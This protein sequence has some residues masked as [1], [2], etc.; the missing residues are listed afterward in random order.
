MRKISSKSTWWNKKAFPAMWFGFLGVFMCVLIPGVTQG[1]APAFLLLWPL[2]LA[3]FGYVLMR[4]LVFSLMDEVWIDGDDIVV[5]NR[6]EE[7]RFPI[8]NIVNVD[9]S[10]MTNPERIVLTLRTPSE[11]GQEIVF[12]PLSRWWPFSRHPLATELI[13]LA[14][15]LDGPGPP[16]QSP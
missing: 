13:R 5:R 12:S 6:G 8:S 7:D 1:Q 16:P 4:E 10:V 14:H 3:V 2:G 15:R 11:F 9:C